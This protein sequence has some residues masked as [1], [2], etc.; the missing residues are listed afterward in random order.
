ML[1]SVE[2][3]PGLCVVLWISSTMA[4][5]NP[6]WLAAFIRG[7]TPGGYRGGRGRGSGRGGGGGG[8]P[9]PGSDRG[10]RGHGHH[11][12]SWSSRS[13]R[14]ARRYV[15]VFFVFLNASCGE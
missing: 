14:N 10:G 9:G 8:G 6:L 7:V 13:E 12:Y 1:R 2:C 5:V 3:S 15:F 11:P 4:Y